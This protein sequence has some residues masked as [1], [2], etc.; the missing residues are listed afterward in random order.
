PLC[1]LEKH[2]QTDQGGKPKCLLLPFPT[3]RA[4][5]R[6]HRARK[7]RSNDLLEAAVIPPIVATDHRA[8]S[9]A[10]RRHRQLRTVLPPSIPHEN[11]A[12]VCALLSARM[13]WRS[14]VAEQIENTVVNGEVAASNLR[15]S[16]FVF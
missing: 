7:P 15:P 3:T 12:R 14:S 13:Q 9:N 5:S 4:E 2:F 8:A 1:F 11:R 6:S 16:I 10:A